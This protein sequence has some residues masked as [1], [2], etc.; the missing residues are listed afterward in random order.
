MPS[1]TGVGDE[2][3]PQAGVLAEQVR[4]FLRVFA[5]LRAEWRTL[6]HV[7]VVEAVREFLFRGSTDEVGVPSNTVSVGVVGLELNVDEFGHLSPPPRC[8]RGPPESPHWRGIT[9][10][11]RPRHRSGP[12]RRGRGLVRHGAR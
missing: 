4:D 8:T 6:T 10:F 7:L 3:T 11:R 5:R 12:L 2:E 9:P 1:L